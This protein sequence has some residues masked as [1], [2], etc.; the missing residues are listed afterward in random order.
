MLVFVPFIAS[1]FCREHCRPQRRFPCHL[2]AYYLEPCA[3]P[4]CATYGV[5]ASILRAYDV[6]GPALC[7]A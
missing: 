4:H 6:L 3:V 2:R 5:I 1:K 7:N